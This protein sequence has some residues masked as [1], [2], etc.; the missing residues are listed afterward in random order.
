MASVITNCTVCGC[1]LSQKRAGALTCS[2]RCR[3]AASRRPN[4]S[5]VTV[6]VTSETD[7][8]P[9]GPTTDRPPRIK[10]CIGCGAKYA[11]FY[12]VICN[13]PEDVDGVN[14]IRPDDVEGDFPLAESHCMN[15]G[16]SRPQ[17]P[18]PEHGGWCHEHCRFMWSQQ[19]IRA[20]LET[21]PE[22]FKRMF[23]HG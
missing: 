21:L 6:S 19:V 17:W 1:D 7:I 2:P 3:K 4:Q 14:W 5:T 22:R 23:P 16:K 12:C 11:G 8:E 18:T 10:T 15:C 20:E 13:C 9:L